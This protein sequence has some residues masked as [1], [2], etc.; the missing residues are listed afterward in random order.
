[1]KSF[2]ELSVYKNYEKT[3]K[4][5]IILNLE[6]ILFVKKEKGNWKEWGC[7][8]YASASGNEYVYVPLES[9]ILLRRILL[10]EIHD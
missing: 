9:Y 7:I 3:E 6:R 5:N 10:G 8:T 2:I 1:M 4:Q